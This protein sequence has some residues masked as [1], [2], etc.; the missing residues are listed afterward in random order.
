[1]ATPLGFGVLCG[2]LT[3]SAS[4]PALIW[5]LAGWPLFCVGVSLWTILQ[6]P[7]GRY[8]LSGLNT[9]GIECFLSDAQLK[10]IGSAKRPLRF[11]SSDI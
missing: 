11:G 5:E 3:S 10:K 9:R 2:S 7:W 1:M 8:R 6:I 4:F